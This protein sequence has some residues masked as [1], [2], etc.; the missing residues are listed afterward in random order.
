LLFA[1]IACHSLPFLIFY[2]INILNIS[3]V[4][5]GNINATVPLIIV[6]SITTP[7]DHLHIDKEK[8]FPY[9]YFIKKEVES[10]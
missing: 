8:K 2:S 3:F 7:Y 5:D 6:A 4:L 9:T 1:L 10:W